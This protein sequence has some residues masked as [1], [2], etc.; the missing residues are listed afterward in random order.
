MPEQEQISLKNPLPGR[1]KMPTK[2]EEYKKYAKQIKSLLASSEIRDLLLK[3]ES[4]IVDYL[5]GKSIWWVVKNIIFSGAIFNI[6]YAGKELFK[7]YKSMADPAMQRALVEHGGVLEFIGGNADIF[8]SIVEKAKNPDE[9]SPLRKIEDMLAPGVL[10]LLKDPKSRETVKQIILK[11]YMKF[12]KAE[13]LVAEGYKHGYYSRGYIGQ[14]APDWM[15]ITEEMLSLISQ[16]EAFPDNLK[17]I[18]EGNAQDIAANFAAIFD[19]RPLIDT[20]NEF[21]ANIPAQEAKAINQQII[22]FWEEKD[23]E[24]GKKIQQKLAEL[25]VDQTILMEEWHLMGPEIIYA[26]KQNKPYAVIDILKRYEVSITD[27]QAASSIKASLSEIWTKYEKDIETETSELTVMENQK[28][29]GLLHENDKGIKQLM[30]FWRNGLG[31]KHAISSNLERFGV[32]QGLIAKAG[33]LL[34]KPQDIE[35]IVHAIRSKPLF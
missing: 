34:Q 20:L 11:N 19:Q 31:V 1:Y 30:D 7:V 23:K 32:A 6:I 14:F 13:E 17:G 18:L 5:K 25:G 22:K 16:Q 27:A 8:Q 2:E 33:S 24:V 35:K 26:L 29:K 3:S 12:P 4:N 15:G 28:V 9:P 10:N 21:G